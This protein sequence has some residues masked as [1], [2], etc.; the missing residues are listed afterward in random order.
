[1]D[2]A[3]STDYGQHDCIGGN[4]VSFVTAIEVGNC[5]GVPFRNTIKNAINLEEIGQIANSRLLIN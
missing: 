5:Y 2:Q 1:M 4:E 3:V